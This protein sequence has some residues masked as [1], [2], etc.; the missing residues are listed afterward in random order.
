MSVLGWGFAARCGE[1][2]ETRDQIHSRSVRIERLIDRNR[3]LSGHHSPLPSLAITQA[4]ITAV[5]PEITRADAHALIELAMRSDYPMQQAALVLLNGVDSKA[6]KLVDDDLTVET[7]P[8]RRSTLHSLARDLRL[9]EAS[10][11][12][13]SATR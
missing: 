13:S 9:M 10:S 5:R 8:Q 7:D 6:S 3:H 12:S 1:P 2:A 11:A 4:T